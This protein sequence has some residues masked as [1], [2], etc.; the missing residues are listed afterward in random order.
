LSPDAV[1]ALQHGFQSCHACGLLSRPSHGLDEGLCP[2]CNGELAFRKPA[3]LQRTW[4]FLLGAG[5]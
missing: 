3:S 5:M 1:T 4:A 2:R